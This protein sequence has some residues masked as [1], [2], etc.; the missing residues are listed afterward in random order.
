MTTTA[1]RP[2]AVVR[3][4]PL[5]AVVRWRSVLVP[6]VGA[7]VLVLLSALS[8][9]RGDFPIGSPTCCG[10]WPASAIRVSSS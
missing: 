10:R 7:V 5:S 2:G 8:L 6:A 1:V 9:G 4:G 3:I